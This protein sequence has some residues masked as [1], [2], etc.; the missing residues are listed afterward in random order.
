MLKRLN[1]LLFILILAVIF[2]MSPVLCTIKPFLIFFKLIIKMQ[3]HQVKKLDLLLLKVSS[4]DENAFE[5][6][7]KF[8]DDQLNGYIMSITRSQSLTEEMVQ[9]VFLKIWLNRES[10]TEIDSFK[11]YLFVIARNHTFDCLKQINRKRK[12]EKEWLNIVVNTPLNDYIE[13]TTDQSQEKI[14][15]AVSLLPPQQKKIYFL[16]SEGAKPQEIAEELS[17]SIG[18]VK[19]HLAL[20]IRFLKNRIRTGGAGPLKN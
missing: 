20:S 4:G 6:L 14:N 13:P 15:E 1:S 17:I 2:W 19:K 3:P 16:R 5:E 11:S 18:T 8:Y 12:R 9:D 10:L 7:L